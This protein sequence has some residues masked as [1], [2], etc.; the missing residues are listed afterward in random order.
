MPLLLNS[1]SI[2]LLGIIVFCDVLTN[3]RYVYSAYLANKFNNSV[4]V[5]LIKWKCMVY[6]SSCMSQIYLT[7]LPFCFG[8]FATITCETFLKNNQKRSSLHNYTQQHK[9]FI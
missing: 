8:S 5:R 7:I 6:A 9:P 2:L 1:C 3:V 4:V